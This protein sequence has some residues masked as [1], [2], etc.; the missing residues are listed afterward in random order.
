[1]PST[2]DYC[3][4][5]LDQLS[6]LPDITTWKM[7]GEYILYYKGKIFG[8]IYDNRLLVKPNEAAKKMMPDAPLEEPYPGAKKM[9]LVEYIQQRIS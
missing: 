5:I 9:L 2:Q 6:F 8:G 4:F 1:M 7:M 3:N